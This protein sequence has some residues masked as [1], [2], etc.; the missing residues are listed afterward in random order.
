DRGSQ[1]RFDTRLRK[2]TMRG[3]ALVGLFSR[4]QHFFCHKLS[5]ERLFYAE[6]DVEKNRLT[7]RFGDVDEGIRD[8]HLRDDASKI[9]ELLADADRSQRRR[10]R[11]PTSTRSRFAGPNTRDIDFWHIQ[12]ARGAV[13][14]RPIKKLHRRPN[15]R[16]PSGAGNSGLTA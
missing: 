7:I 12:I 9:V 8:G 4:A 11:R 3:G 15:L 6:L 1:S 14:G 13:I 5:V 10:I 16:E 2:V